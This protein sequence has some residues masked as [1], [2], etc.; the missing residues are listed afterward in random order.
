MANGERPSHGHDAEQSGLLQIDAAVLG[1]DATEPGKA[2]LVRARGFCEQFGER[3]LAA[4][5]IE[6][7]APNAGRKPGLAVH[8]AQ[9][10]EDVDREK[11]VGARTAYPVLDASVPGGDRP[12]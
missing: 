2:R 1:L 12:S 6:G 4:S 9:I 10:E 3:G 11:I 5:H 8:L 7:G